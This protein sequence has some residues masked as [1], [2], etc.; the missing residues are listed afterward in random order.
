MLIEAG[1]ALANGKKCYLAIKKGIHTT[2]MKEI[3]DM[4]IEFENLE[5]LYDKLSKLK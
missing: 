1:Y 2:F 4:V 5:D 3:A